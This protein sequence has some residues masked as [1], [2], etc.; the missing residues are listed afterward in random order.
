MYPLST[1][2]LELYVAGLEMVNASSREMTPAICPRTGSHCLV[3]GPTGAA[4]RLGLKRS[5]LQ[6]KMLQLGITRDDYNGPPRES[7]S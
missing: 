4:H 1:P 2:S 6:S 3:S 7:G 5:T